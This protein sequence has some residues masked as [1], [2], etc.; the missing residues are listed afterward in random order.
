MFKLFA[1]LTFL[2]SIIG[3][4]GLVSFMIESR[5][6][7]MSIRKVMGAGTVE[8]V[9]QLSKEF[10]ILVC[11]AAVI[12]VPVVW[13]F[14]KDWLQNFAYSAPMGLGN[15]LAV[16]ILALLV[17]LTVVGFQAIRAAFRNT[18]K[19]LRSE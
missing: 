5:A 4:V 11:L 17:T 10:F 13:Y 2:I 3:L 7:E 8:I 18:V 1:G 16:I 12:A 6:K 9:S 19:G 14:G 15:F